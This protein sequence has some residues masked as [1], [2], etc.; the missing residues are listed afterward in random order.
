MGQ[1]AAGPGT[2]GQIEPGEPRQV[3]LGVRS[4]MLVRRRAGLSYDDGVTEPTRPR[5]RWGWILGCIVLGLTAIAAGFLLLD[6]SARRGYVASVLAGVGTTLLL[7]GIV[8]LLERRIVDTAA[9]AVR[10]VVDAER[11]AR[12]ARIKQLTS[13]L[14]ERLTAEWA[15]AGPEDVE[16]RTAE[17]TRQTV[18][19]IEDEAEEAARRQTS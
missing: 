7:V 8:V 11:Q 14:E 19:R 17:L 13:E 4:L 2:P 18:D 3:S 5:I 1:P 9:K 12:D 6:P 16:A 15:S 10:R